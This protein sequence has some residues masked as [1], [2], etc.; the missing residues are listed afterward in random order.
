MTPTGS[1]SHAT[2]LAD[3]ASEQSTATPP[4]GGGGPSSSSSA[5]ATNPS[6]L[7]HNV[8]DLQ[9]LVTEQ[10]Q[11]I[12]ELESKL[13]ESEQRAT[14]AVRLKLAAVKELETNKKFM[15]TDLKSVELLKTQV[16]DEHQTNASLIIF[17]RSL[18]TQVAE[19]EGYI[20]TLLQQKGASQFDIA[21]IMAEIEKHKPVMP[22]IKK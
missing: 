4:R 1:S 2:V 9:T 13:K 12:A 21:A 18:K 10:S 7:P 22:V 6:N 17:N 16:Q 20:E 14:D 3:L 15:H 19:L 5:S 11:R 8:E